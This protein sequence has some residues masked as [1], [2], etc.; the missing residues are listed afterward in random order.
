MPFRLAHYP[1]HNRKKTKENYTGQTNAQI[2]PWLILF[3][4]RFQKV[5]SQKKGNNFWSIFKNNF[6]NLGRNKIF[7]WI[8]WNLFHHYLK[9]SIQRA[10]LILKFQKPKIVQNKAPGLNLGLIK[11]IMKF[12]NLNLENIVE[13]VV[14][15]IPPIFFILR[16]YRD[17]KFGCFCDFLHFKVL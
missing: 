7:L 11:N 1:E 12:W 6:R 17:T 5:T 9:F 10:W 13:G 16:S 8:N 14:S 2:L 15:I 3:T 4:Q